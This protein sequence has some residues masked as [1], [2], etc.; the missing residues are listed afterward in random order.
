MNTLK[1]ADHFGIEISDYKLNIDKVHDRKENIISDLRKGI[2]QL[3]GAHGVEVI[4]GFGKLTTKNQVTVTLNDGSEVQLEAKILLLQ[5]VLSLKVSP[6]LEAIY[7]AYD[8]S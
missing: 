7:K 1:D 5:L 2:H 8:Q 3:M 4:E 6:F